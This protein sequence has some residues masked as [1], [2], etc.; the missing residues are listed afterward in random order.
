MI[1]VILSDKQLCR[2]FSL[3]QMLYWCTV[4]SSSTYIVS[5]MTA[6]RQVSATMTGNLLAVYMLAGVA[7]QF[8]INSICDRFQNNRKVFMGGMLITLL[9]WLGVY[10]APGLGLVF[11]LYGLLGFMQPTMSA[12]LDTWLI[13]SFPN[14]AGAYSP[15]RSLGSL[16]YSCLMLVMGFA[17]DG[18]G[19]I[20]MVLLPAL[21]T[22]G[23]IVVAQ[24]MPEI[25]PL[26]RRRERA[27]RAEAGMHS[28]A[29]VVWMCMLVMVM[30]GMANMPLLNMNLMIMENAGGGVT[31]QG[32]AISFN[33]V[34][35]FLTMR[36]FM[37]WISRA[38]ATRKLQFSGLLYLISVVM[39]V[40]FKSIPA[41]YAAYFINGVSYGVLLPARRQFVNEMVPESLLNRMHGMGDMAYN[42]V[43]GL[44]GNKF[45]GTIIDQRGVGFMVM[46]SMLLDAV[47]FALLLTFGPIHRRWKQ[48]RGIDRAA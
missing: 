35:E 16:A 42:S 32:I 5:Y 33:T 20:V 45:S 10:F 40:S 30:M 48:W 31:H 25:P 26:E 43:G 4:G 12:V 18:I 28:M 9:I 47:S 6:V 23:A 2:G 36:F 38:S 29:T 46:L 1:G 19:H 7:G 15:I 8:L 34:A 11:A 24:F 22:V 3:L 17:I 41:L 27:A 13:R 39:I 21:F 14:D 37:R 44:I